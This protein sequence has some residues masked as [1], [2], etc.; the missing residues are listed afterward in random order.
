MVSLQWP[1]SEE[2]ANTERHGIKVRRVLCRNTNMDSLA[3][4]LGAE[5]TRQMKN[6]DA[7][8]HTADSIPAF[9]D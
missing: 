6:K 9:L 1:T 3:E 2:V 4:G 8:R 7:S 5:E